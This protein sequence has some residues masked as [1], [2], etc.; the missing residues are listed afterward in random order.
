MY[1]KFA[2]FLFALLPM[3]Y[4][5]LKIS[6]VICRSVVTS[7]RKKKE[8]EEGYGD[9]PLTYDKVIV[10]VIVSWSPFAKLTGLNVFSAIIVPL[11]EAVKRPAFWTLV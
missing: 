8:K 3:R 4:I 10:Q 2:I 6:I 7:G 1:T 5:V 9:L 11:E